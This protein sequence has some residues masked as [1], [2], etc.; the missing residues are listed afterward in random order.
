MEC[1]IWPLYEYENGKYKITVKPKEKKPIEEYL[2]M[3]GRFGHLFKLK[4]NT[5]IPDFQAEI[6]RQWERLLKRSAE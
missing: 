6:D 3:Q 1:C 2:K 5:T 4:D